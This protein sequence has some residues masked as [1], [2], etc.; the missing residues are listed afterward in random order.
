MPDLFQKKIGEPIPAAAPHPQPN[1]SPQ[2][3]PE[4]M[5]PRSLSDY[6]GQ[7]HLLSPG[8]LLRRAIEANRLSSIL[9]HGPPGTGKTT[10][11]RIIADSTRASFEPFSGVENSVADLRR[12]LQRANERRSATGVATLLFVDEIH[13]L[14]KAQQDVLL[15][16]LEDGSVK[17]MGATTHNPYFV[18]SSAL[19]SRSQ[20]FQL[21]PLTPLHLCELQRRAI[22]DCQKG[23]GNLHI[24]ITPE[25]LEHFAHHSEGDARKCL[26]ALEL[27]ALTTPP[28]Q[29]GM[30]AIDLAVARESIQRKAVVYDRDGD[31][32][33]DTIS[34]LIKSVRGGDP[35]AALYWLARM[36]IAGEDIRFLARRLVILASEDVGLADSGALSVAVA[37]QH[38]VEI[39]GLP[40]A[41]IPLA[42]ATVY[43]ATAPKSNRA[44]AALLAA[45]KD[46]ESGHSLAV[47]R[48]LRDTHFKGAKA[49]GHSGYMNPHDFEGSFVPQAYLEE[50][51]RYYHPAEQG[52]ERRIKERL[53]Y[54][55]SLHEQSQE[56]GRRHGA[57][58]S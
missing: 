30:V 26:G 41:Q 10:L 15:P 46:V 27:A 33:Y 49:M 19:I 16:A 14:N 47:P 4:R 23:L 31:Q 3:L 25:A 40:E 48:A 5:R 22:R 1:A 35:D 51:R 32:H 29:G 37:A 36:L 18:L 55:R 8:K 53:E 39:T 38:A 7:E 28:N 56:G 57:P 45:R 54:W 20:V 9:L 42:H 43:L 11:A 58:E 34:A 12:A 52:A 24:E 21:E 13:R 17:F 2:P 44:Y 50:G 6:M